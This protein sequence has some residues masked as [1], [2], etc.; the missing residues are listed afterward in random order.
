MSLSEQ[1]GQVLHAYVAAR[2]DRV[3]TERWLSQ[4]VQSVQDEHDE[5]VSQLIGLAYSLFAEIGYG[6]R[7]EAEA[8]S[9]LAEALG[10]ARVTQISWTEPLLTT[11]SGAPPFAP[12]TPFPPASNVHHEVGIQRSPVIA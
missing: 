8:R 5:T 3:F 9:R 12:P 1:V 7:T 6:H 2:I 4:R 10:G 11:A